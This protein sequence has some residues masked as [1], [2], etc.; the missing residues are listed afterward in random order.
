MIDDLVPGGVELC[1]AYGDAG[2]EATACLFPAEQ[3][4]VR[5]VSEERRREFTTVRGCAR[6]ALARL[7]IPSEPLVPDVSGAPRW[8]RGTVGSLTH[9]P[10]YRAAVAARAGEYAALGIDAEPAAP[11]PAV[12]AARI[13]PDAERRSADDLRTALGVPADRLV[14]CAKEASYKA[15][16]PWLGRRYGLRDFA[17]RPR[18]DGL[19]RGVVPGG[20]HRF[21][22]RWAVRS[23]YF[24]VVVCLASAQWSGLLAT[25]V[26]RGSG[27]QQAVI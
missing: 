6:R 3:A 9:C 10:G 11:L 13:L 26:S 23:G 12:V 20:R 16:S 18:A 2:P 21:E 7:G 27:W 17:V 25:G 22:G 1:E 8:P 24:V 5:G 19:F 4:V 14:F 15:F